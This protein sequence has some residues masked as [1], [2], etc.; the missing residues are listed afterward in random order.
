MP[1]NHLPSSHVFPVLLHLFI[2][3][4]VVIMRRAWKLMDRNNRGRPSNC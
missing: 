1:I 4:A 2:A 3:V